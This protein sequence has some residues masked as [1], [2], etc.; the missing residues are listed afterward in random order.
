MMRS[1]HGGV[2]AAVALAA[3]TSVPPPVPVPPDPLLPFA[4]AGGP[5]AIRLM[6]EVAGLVRAHATHAAARHAARHAEELRAGLAAASPAVWQD[7]M[8]AATV[9]DG[10]PAAWTQLVR[11]RLEKP[12]VYA[13]LEAARASAAAALVRGEVEEALA[14]SQAAA[15]EAPFGLARGHALAWYAFAASALGREDAQPTFLAVA[16]ELAVV[17]PNDAAEV[18]LTAHTCQPSDATWTSAVTTAGTALAARPALAVPRLWWRA[19]ETRPPAVPWPAPVL[20]ALAG[21]CFVAREPDVMAEDGDVIVRHGLAE[22]ER[23]RGGAL[24]A[25][26]AFR[27]AEEGARSPLTRALCQAGQAKALMMLGRSGDARSVLTVTV[28]EPLP[29]AKALGLATL[30]AIELAG[31]RPVVARELL[32]QALEIAPEETWPGRADAM[33]NYALALLTA[34]DGDAGVQWLHRARDA[35]AALGNHDGLTSC[36]DNEAAW[37]TG[38]QQRDASEVQKQIDEVARSGMLTK[39]APLPKY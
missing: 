22:M 4:V 30:G 32:R 28:Q 21:S 33:A 17:S 38:W 1:V 19:L 6:Q 29:A 7:A 27:K 3:C 20:Q 9:V 24:A 10:D 39:A 34:G 2:F 14:T 23:R 18:L 16:K 8:V 26:V 35:F 5:G 31:D 12:A 15:A 11:D 13:R 37:L 25:M 36:L